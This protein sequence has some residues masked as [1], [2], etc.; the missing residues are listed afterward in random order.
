[1]YKICTKQNRKVSL[2]SNFLVLSSKVTIFPFVFLI[3]S[4]LLLEALAET[5]VK[6]KTKNINVIPVN[7]N[8]NPKTPNQF[9]KAA[10]Y[11]IINNWPKQ[12]NIR[13]MIKQNQEIL[14]T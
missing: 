13:E 11:I 4:S 12:C 10:I 1:M 7:K 3:R 6:N 5:A 9:F 8:F 14:S 2:I